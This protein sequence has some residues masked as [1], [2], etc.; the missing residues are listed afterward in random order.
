MSD[1]D[2]RSS[3]HIPVDSLMT[4]MALS[5]PLRGIPTK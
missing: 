2:P 4:P 1:Q 3:K 5:G